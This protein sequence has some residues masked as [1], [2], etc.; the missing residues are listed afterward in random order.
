ML[1]NVWNTRKEKEVERKEANRKED[2]MAATM[3]E[4][5][6]PQLITN[7]EWGMMDKSKFYPLYT[8][9]SFTGAYVRLFFKVN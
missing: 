3:V 5:P 2:K 4:T 7:I 8:L 1:L 9:S 6:P